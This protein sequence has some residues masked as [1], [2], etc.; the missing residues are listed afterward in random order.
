[1]FLP[2]AILFGGK[3]EGSLEILKDRYTS[4]KTYIYVCENSVCELPVEES[5][6]AIEQLL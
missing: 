6:K 1:M 2:N 3:G 5:N 4:G